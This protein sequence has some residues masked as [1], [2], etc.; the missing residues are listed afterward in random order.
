M[1][2]TV[3]SI[4]PRHCVLCEN[5][6]G[7][8][9]ARK[10]EGGRIIAQN[11][12]LVTSIALDP[13]EKKPLSHFFP[14]STVL[15]VG[16]FGCN[17]R[18]PF[19][20]NHDISMADEHTPKTRHVTPQELVGMALSFMNRG[21]IGVAYTYN[22]P[23]VGFEYVRDCAAAVKRKG[24]KNVLVTNGCFCEEPVKE[25]LP[26]IDAMNID[27]KGFTREFYRKV[28]GDLETVKR[29][30]E[31][32]AKSCHVEVTTLI[33]PGENDGEDEIR[34]LSRW[35]SSLSAKIPLHLTRFFP[36]YR[37]EYLLPTETAHLRALAGIARESLD[38]V[39]VGN[40]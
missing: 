29:T 13:I 23:L 1:N 25:L 7:F 8:C 12:A 18:C 36:R 37:M 4:C 20:Q 38:F 10:N 9:R 17:L 28:G 2:K 39:H 32:S 26:D 14:G 27:L 33:I 24:L 31:L 3:C 30:I 19:C 40:C 11:Y 35:L 21:N 22:E 16:S 15:S 6:T 34:E 5:E